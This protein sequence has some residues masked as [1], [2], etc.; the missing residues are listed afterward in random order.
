MEEADAVELLLRSSLTKSTPEKKQ[1]A[2][3]IVQVS[4]A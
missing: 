3:G 4:M 2:R 1:I